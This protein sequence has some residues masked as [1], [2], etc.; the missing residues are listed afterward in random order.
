VARPTAFVI[1]CLACLGVA[2]LL[3]QGGANGGSGSGVIQV[4]PGQLQAAIERARAG[5]RLVIH[6]GRYRGAFVIGK[7]L[8]IVGA[9]GRK[10]PVID[11][12]CATRVTIAVRAP[13]VVLRHLHVVG[14]TEGFGSLPTEVDFSGVASGRAVDLVVRDTCDAEY[15]I[16]VF[17]SQ[18]VDVIDNRG[19]GFSDAPFYVGSIRDTGGGVLRVRGNEGFASNRGIIVEDSAGGRIVVHDN[20]L[21]GNRAP[22][23]GVPTGIFL[24]RSDGVLLTENV[25][26]G[27][28]RFGIHLDP[29]SDRNRLFANT[30]RRNPGGNL[31]NEGSGNCG[32]R[33]RPDVLPPCG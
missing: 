12:G 23:E 1:A 10:R 31:R 19:F 3:L 24:H 25:V 29:G 6:P 15:G 11:G 2:A 17:G 14:A 33:N 16:N 22:G 30:A 27:N 9:A 20:R 26:V 28:G 4:R 32:A 13:G 18:R 8:T 5:D 21:H 7:R